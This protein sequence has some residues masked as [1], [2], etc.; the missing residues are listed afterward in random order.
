MTYVKQLE[1]YEEAV[2]ARRLS[3]MA[4]DE[5]DRLMVEV[6]PS[7]PGNIDAS[8]LALCPRVSNALAKLSWSAVSSSVFVCL[9]LMRWGTDWLST[10]QIPFRPDSAVARRKRWTCNTSD[11]LVQKF[12]HLCRVEL[13]AEWE[14]AA[15]Q[16]DQETQARQSK[17]KKLLDEQVKDGGK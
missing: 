4:P 7:P 10:S 11:T 16:V 3:E 15:G 14:R 1:D 5:L 12:N 17:K 13:G 8:L 6:H 2:M 9:S